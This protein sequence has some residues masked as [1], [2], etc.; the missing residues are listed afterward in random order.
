MLSPISAA[1]RVAVDAVLMGADPLFLMLPLNLRP[2]VL[3][4]AETGVGDKGL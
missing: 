1:A 2:A 3:V 4:A